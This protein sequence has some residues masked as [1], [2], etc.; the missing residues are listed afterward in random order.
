MNR[1][2]LVKRASKMKPP[3]P[4]FAFGKYKGQFV[5]TVLKKDPGYIVWC[6]RNVAKSYLPF[7]KDVYDQAYASEQENELNAHC[8]DDYDELDFWAMMEH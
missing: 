7:N 6:W 4:K 8:D 5:E 3:K 1:D 2:E